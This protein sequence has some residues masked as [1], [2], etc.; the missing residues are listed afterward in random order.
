M[1]EYQSIVEI[2]IKVLFGWDMNKKQGGVAIFG[3]IKAHSVAHE[4]QGRNTLLGHC[5]IWLDSV[6]KLRERLYHTDLTVRL[7]SRR[8]FLEYVG[9]V[10]NASY[11]DT[12]L[13]VWHK[14]GEKP[15]L[16]F[17]SFTPGL[18][19]VHNRNVDHLFFDYNK[20]SPAEYQAQLQHL[21]NT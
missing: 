8:N 9:K 2:T 3:K 20:D 14:F 1:L 6:S 4:E 19:T 11:N 18:D 16:Q 5:H 7:Q 13:T 15:C 10:M 12:G 21:H 17:P